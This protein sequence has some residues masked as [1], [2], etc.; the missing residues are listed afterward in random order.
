MDGSLSFEELV[1]L[2][3][4]KNAY[5]L[6]GQTAFHDFGVRGAQ[7]LQWLRWMVANGRLDGDDS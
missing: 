1:R 4:F 2:Q 7:C 6:S 3:R 5:A